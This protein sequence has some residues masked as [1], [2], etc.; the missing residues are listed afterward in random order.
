MSRDKVDVARRVVD[1]YNRFDVAGLFAEFLTA[2]FEW[3][4]AT[5]KALEGDAYRGREGIERFTA[6]TEEDWD[7]LRVIA[8]EFRELDDRVVILGRLTG[9]GKVSGVPVDQP[10]ASILDF[11]GDRVW[12]TRVYVDRAE[13]LREAGLPE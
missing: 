4:P 12:R 6:D 11:R 2:D 1:G 7:E 10:M 8:E 5:V 9:H 3:Y 13:A